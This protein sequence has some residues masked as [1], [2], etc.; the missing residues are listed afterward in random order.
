MDETHLPASTLFCLF[1]F[2][3]FVFISYKWEE[4]DK[5]RRNVGGERE[6]EEAKWEEKEEERG[7][8]GRRREK[9][10]ERGKKEK[11]ERGKR[12]GGGEGGRKG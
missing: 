3:L 2:F 10:I 7:G 11:E 1:S 9:E 5:E 12:E 6:R 4:G 8:R